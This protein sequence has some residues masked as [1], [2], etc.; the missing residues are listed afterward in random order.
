MSR[1]TGG[2]S[3]KRPRALERARVGWPR[4][5]QELKDLLY[6]VYL[7]AGMPSL[8]E[9]AKDVADDDGL[10]GSPSRDTVRRCISD[11]VLPPGQADVASIA[12]VLARRAAW[13][14]QDLAGRV[15]G[16]WVAARMATGAGQLIGEFDDR[17]VLDDLGVHRALDAGADCERL[18]ALPAYVPREFDNR[19]DAVVAAAAAGQSGIAALVGG[20]STGKSRALWEAAKRLPDTWRL[21]HPLT[22]TAAL[23]ELP[24]VAPRT[25]VWL[26]EAQHYLSP[27][28]LGEHVSA[29]LQNLLRDPARGPVLVLATLWPGHWQTLTT[30]TPEDRHPQARAL[31]SGH[32][33]DVPEAFTLTD[34]VALADTAGNDA[35]LQEAA[36]RAHAAQITQYLAGVPVLTDRYH[37]APGATRALIHAAMDARRLGASPHIPLAWLADAAPGYLTKAKWNATGDDWLAQALDYVTQECNG[38]PGILTPVKTISRNQRNRRSAASSSPAA[39]QPARDMPG[40]QYQL[41][42]YLDQYGRLHRADQIPPIDFWTAAANHAHPADLA[43]LSAAAWKRGLYRDAAQLLK[44][45]SHSEPWAA[46]QLLRQFHRM[47]STDRRPAQWVVDQVPLEEPDKVVQLLAALQ[48]VG[49]SQQF[50]DLLARDPAASVAVDDA[51]AVGRLLKA[52]SEVA[53]HEQT[54]AL[55]ERAARHIHPDDPSHV[56]FLLETM[57]EIGCHEQVAVILTGDPAARVTVEDYFAVGRLLKALSEVAAHEQTAALAERAARHF[58]LDDPHHAIW[59]MESMREVG[60]YE[61]AAALAERAARHA[62]LDSKGSASFMLQ[63]LRK[64]GSYT[65]AARLTERAAAQSALDNPADVTWL[66]DRLLRSKSY[67]QTAALLERDPAADVTFDNHDALAKLLK[68]LRAAGAHVQA[69]ALEERVA[70]HVIVASARYMSPLVERLR[71]SGVLERVTTLLARDPAPHVA[72]RDPFAMRHLLEELGKLQNDEQIEALTDWAVSHINLD[73]PSAVGWFLV[74]L[75]EVGAHDHAFALAERAARH[76]IPD[77][78]EGVVRLLNHMRKIQAYEQ[79]TALAQRASAHMAL[80]HPSDVSILLVKLWETGSHELATVVA[81]G[82]A[83]HIP[84]SSTGAVSVLLDRMASVGA[85]KEAAALA[86]RAAPYAALDD[87]QAVASLLETLSKWG[88]HQQTAVILSRD[89]ASHAALHDSQVVYRLWVR[90]Q[91]VG[92]HE[93]ATCLAERLP[94]AGHFDLYIQMLNHGQRFKYGREPDGSAAAPWTWEDLE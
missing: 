45:A 32:K 74:D 33:I 39:G 52:L 36:Q 68:K 88:Y 10:Q 44:R 54:A 56:V 81:V 46:A 94:A 91:E 1:D 78:W 4:P 21:W 89:P 61:Q 23:A 53:A 79:A 2:G 75:W 93:Q 14:R 87:P 57:R 83:A 30:R 51:Y 84:A 8:D 43:A 55:A 5:L 29:G 86:E 27:D 12:E 50:T 35:R 59:L 15:R 92:A 62:P 34:L 19:L 28:Q 77:D 7:A 66:L 24:D 85:R 48:D 65:Q 63:S 16:L 60:A 90:L 47:P 17:L 20:S 13:D 82:A 76:L 9:I 41:A 22:P 18:G 3:V 31:I 58:P 11:P 26:N 72:L 70:T 40:P 38:I 69:A 6:E 71:K 67:E 64:S 73:S 25:V 80:H 49:A 42:D 37:T